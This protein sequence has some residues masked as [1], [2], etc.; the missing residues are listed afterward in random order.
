M[1]D[2]V[3]ILGDRRIWRPV[4]LHFGISQKGMRIQRLVSWKAVE[5][6]M[7]IKSLNLKEPAV[8]TVV[9]VNEL[10]TLRESDSLTRFLLAV[11]L[12]AV[13]L[14]MAVHDVIEISRRRILT[15]HSGLV[16]EYCLS[17]ILHAEIRFPVVASH[18]E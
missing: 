14:V 1:F 12:V 8:L 7:R 6:F 10:K 11:H 13:H 15:H 4:G 2:G 18:D 17:V 5:R 3:F 16:H 9:S